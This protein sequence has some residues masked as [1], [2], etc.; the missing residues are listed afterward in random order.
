M[1]RRRK[2]ECQLLADTQVSCSPVQFGH[3]T[4]GSRRPRQRTNGFVQFPSAY[5]AGPATHSHGITS[6]P[7]DRVE[8][9]GGRRELALTPPV[10]G[11][12]SFATSATLCADHIAATWSCPVLQK[13]RKCLI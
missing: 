4:K 6:K 1:Q 13:R 2:F 7:L 11:S 10:L 5:A 8:F 3:L 12:E 9:G